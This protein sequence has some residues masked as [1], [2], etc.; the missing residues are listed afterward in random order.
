MS[1]E[2][3]SEELIKSQTKE[4][5]IERRMMAQLKKKISLYTPEQ[6][7][8]L[9]NEEKDEY[10]YFT[11][12]IS[13]RKQEKQLRHREY[14]KE[15]NKSHKEDINRNMKKYYV[16]NKDEKQKKN[17]DN[18]YKNKGVDISDIEYLIKVY[19]EQQIAK[20]NNVV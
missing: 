3:N 2:L 15:Y 12:T 17:L 16:K 6:I 8:N 10:E 9:A 7:A 13:R 4:K 19:K 20:M 14:M 18:Y 1:S 5:V 11:T